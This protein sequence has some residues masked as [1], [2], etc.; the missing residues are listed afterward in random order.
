MGC[1]TYFTGGDAG[2]TMMTC[3]SRVQVGT[4]ST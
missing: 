2:H 1:V 3:F 4:I